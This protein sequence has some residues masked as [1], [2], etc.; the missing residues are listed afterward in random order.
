M[1]ETDS[2]TV[3]VVQAYYDIL[4]G[5]MA[6]FDPDRLRAVGAPGQGNSTGA[7]PRP[8]EGGRKGSGPP[9]AASAVVRSRP[10]GSRIGS[11]SAPARH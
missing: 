6:T 3:Q 5:G 1:P 11:A 2:S 7:L 10:L 9:G 4:T 8:A